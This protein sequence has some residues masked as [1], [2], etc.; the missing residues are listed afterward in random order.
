M[1]ERAEDGESEDELASGDEGETKEGGAG[2]EPFGVVEEAVDA[3]V[4][5]LRRELLE[6]EEVGVEPA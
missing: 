6:K 3:S 1:A 2:H 5:E 4:G